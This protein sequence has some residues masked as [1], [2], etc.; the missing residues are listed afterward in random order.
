MISRVLLVAG[1]LL[2]WMGPVEKVC[3]HGFKGRSNT[4]SLVRVRSAQHWV[5]EELA[6]RFKGAARISLG[7]P[8]RSGLPACSRRMVRTVRTG[9]PHQLVGMSIGF[10]EVGRIPLAGLN[11]RL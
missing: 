7:N 8:F 5:K 6:F 3:G 4:I 1:A 10:G 9:V 11:C 2:I